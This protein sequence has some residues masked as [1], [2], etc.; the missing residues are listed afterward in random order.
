MA[1]ATADR[2]TQLSDGS[3]VRTW[4]N[5]ATGKHMRAVHDMLLALADLQAGA[6]EHEYNARPHSTPANRYAF[7]ELVIRLLKA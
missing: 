1:S 3:Y 2:W 4:Y 5:T 6:W 7:T